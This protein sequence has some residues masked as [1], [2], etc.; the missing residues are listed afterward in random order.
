LNSSLVGGGV[1][2][3]GA[4]FFCAIAIGQ[5]EVNTRQKLSAATIK[6][7]DFWRSITGETLRT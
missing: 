7:V 3:T 1:A 5:T 6:L 4:V 2:S